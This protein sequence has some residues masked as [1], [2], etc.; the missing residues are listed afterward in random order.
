MAESFQ[1]DELGGEYRIVDGNEQVAVWLPMT[2]EEKKAVI[3]KAKA[4]KLNLP[5][6]LATYVRE[7]MKGG[8]SSEVFIEDLA[9]VVGGAV[10]LQAPTVKAGT[11]MATMMCPW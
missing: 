2:R 6:V 10:A 5:L 1:V 9:K 11:H 4:D 7:W 3:E 8:K